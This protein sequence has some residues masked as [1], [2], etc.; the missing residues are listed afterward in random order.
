MLSVLPSADLWVRRL[1]PRAVRI[2]VA[3]SSSHQ[4][5][6]SEI[7]SDNPCYQHLSGYAPLFG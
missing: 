4:V 2:D 5:S 6:Q 1:I 7:G 3:K